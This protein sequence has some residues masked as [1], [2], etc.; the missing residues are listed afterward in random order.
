MA[1]FNGG[2]SCELRNDDIVRLATSSTG[3]SVTGTL[4]ATA[5][6]G[7]GSGLTNLPAGGVAGI[8]SSANATAITIDSSERVGIG[9]NSP[10][11]PLHVNATAAGQ[12]VARFESGHA[13]SMA[14]AIDAD[15]DRDSFLEF[16][17]AGTLRWDF[18]MNGSSGTTPLKIRSDNGTTRLELKQDG[19][20]LSQFTAKAWGWFGGAGSITLHDSH[21]V[22]SM[23][24]NGTGTYRANFT[25][26]LANNTWSGTLAMQPNSN[27]DEIIF[28][29]THGTTYFDMISVRSG[30][31]QT[32]ADAYRVSFQVFG[33]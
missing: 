10:Q 3:C 5:V 25:N 15:T 30:H 4:A 18:W 1:T 16:R 14:V 17:E 27:W 9:Q 29:S 20:G 19:R 32:L 21:N 11:S 31:S 33:D 6:T 22:S 24:D 26:A 28:E 2:S 23:T 7:D 13:G 12:T 8:T